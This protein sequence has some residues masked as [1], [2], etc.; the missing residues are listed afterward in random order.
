MDPADCHVLYVDKRATRERFE[1]KPAL[2][3]SFGTSL[4]GYGQEVRAVRQ[5]L[6]AILAV[7]DG[8][9]YA[10]YSLRNVSCGGFLL[11]AVHG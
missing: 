8:G 9:T 1:R 11:P 4:A 5:N 6:D 10:V 2:A 3:S 7:F